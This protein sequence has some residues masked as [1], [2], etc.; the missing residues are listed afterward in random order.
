ML[1]QYGNV[2]LNN[3]GGLFQPALDLGLAGSLL[4]WCGY[5]FV[6]GRFYRGYQVGTLAGVTIYPLIYLSILEVPLV[7]F[8]FYPRMFPGLVTLATVAWMTRSSAEPEPPAAMSPVL[9]KAT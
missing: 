2:E 3:E 6:A 9:E 1:E 4:F 8:L 5:G 7:L